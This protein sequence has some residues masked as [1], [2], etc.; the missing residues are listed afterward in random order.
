[1]NKLKQI[2]ILICIL[3]GTGVFA[4]TLSPKVFA[5]AGND[6]TNG[7][8]HLSYTIGEL[9]VPTGNSNGFYLTQGF[10][11]PEWLIIGIPDA[12]NEINFSVYPNPTVE[13]IYVDMFIPEEEKI[14]FEVEIYDVMGKKYVVPAE[15][16]QVSKGSRITIN[17]GNLS[18]GQYFIRLIPD[19]YKHQ[20]VEFSVIKTN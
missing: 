2:F 19:S 9:I 16:Q 7:S 17:M 12:K 8:F 5:V 6:A 14:N 15:N 10:Q 4:Q 1:M 20:I 18:Q 11:Q 3:W 13:S